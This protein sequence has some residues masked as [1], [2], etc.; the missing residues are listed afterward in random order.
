M[1]K[2][3]VAASLLKLA[4]SLLAEDNPQINKKSNGDGGYIALYKGKK[5][6]VYA[7]TSLAARDL[8]VKYFKAKKAYEV[9]VHLAEN[10]AGEPVTHHADF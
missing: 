5:A 7:K 10:A 6:E 1:D 8:A 9:T 2:K 3:M 4:K